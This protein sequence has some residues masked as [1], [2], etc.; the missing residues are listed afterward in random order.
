MSQSEENGVQLEGSEL[1]AVQEKVKSVQDH[2]SD[3][4]QTLVSKLRGTSG[5]S[6]EITTV[7]YGV[8]T[9]IVRTA[10]GYCYV[11]DGK[12][13]VCRL[14]DGVSEGET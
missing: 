14:C 3:L 9:L 11:Y 7:T 6:T 10:D 2:M 13:G 8:K 4:A 12:R 5:G 1:H